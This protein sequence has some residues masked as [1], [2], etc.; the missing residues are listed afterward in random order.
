MLKYGAF[1]K[2]LILEGEWYR[3]ISSMFLHIGFQHFLF[4]TFS[5]IIFAAGLE[6]TIGSIRYLVVYLLSGLGGSLLT[7]Y[8][9]GDVLAAGASGAI[10]GV[11][12]AFLAILANKNYYLDKGT[13]QTFLAIL[14]INFIFT[15][16]EPNISITGHIGGLIAGFFVALIVTLKK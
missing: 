15:F 14:I 7:F 3:F 2:P 1:Y 6:K 9:S 13:K 8:F 16:L 11:F 12:G 5:L 10:F 4:N